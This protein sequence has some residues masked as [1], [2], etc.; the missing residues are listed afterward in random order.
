MVFQLR[1]LTFTAILFGIAI[2]A[3]L[4]GTQVTYYLGQSQTKTAVETQVTTLT[5]EQRI[6]ANNI[7]EV[8]V[9][10]HKFL[11]FIAVNSTGTCT[12]FS[13]EENNTFTQYSFRDSFS[14][15]TNSYLQINT[16]IYAT[17]TIY[18]TSTNYVGITCPTRPT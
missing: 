6:F 7:T 13:Y 3:L 12:S 14:N 8:V 5:V 9:V 10:E 15:M 11:T 18:V 17:P 1:K 4:V 16:T 2:F